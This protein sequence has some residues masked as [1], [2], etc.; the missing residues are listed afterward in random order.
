MSSKFRFFEDILSQQTP[1]IDDTLTLKDQS[2]VEKAVLQ[3]FEIFEECA[4]LDPEL[5][6]IKRKVHVGYLK[7]SLCHIPRAYECLDASRPW[8]CYWILNALW[9]LNEMPDSNTLSHVVTFLSKCQHE[10]G[11]YGGGPGQD[12]HLAPTY[13]AINALTIIGTQEAYDSINRNTLQQFLWGVRSVDGA[14]AMHRGG[15]V[16]VRGTYCALNVAKLTN[17]FTDALFDKTAEWI[18]SCQTYEGGFGGSQGME[19]HGG[20][21]F[22][23]IAGLTILG[24]PHLCD[25]DALLR[26][27]V[28][29]QMKLEG[30]FQGRTNKLVD[31]CYSFWQGGIFPIIH[32]I[33]FQ[34]D[35]ISLDGLLFNQGALQEYILVCCENP[36]GGFIDKPGK[37]RD[38]Y[39]TNYVLSGL[40]IAQHGLGS[41]SD[42]VGNP[43]NKLNRVH[44]VHCI[45]PHLAYNGSQ[46]FTKY[47][48]SPNDKN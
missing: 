32:T 9:L 35:G 26:W 40:S 21:A 8:M 48:A 14:F 7:S 45:A 1:D 23:A 42:V 17:L 44:P 4:S 19:A 12:S 10:E 25:I 46:Y 20:Y 38:L 36:S 47:P 18:V 37:R 30:G 11:G 34:R 31:G 13:A 27:C 16:D 15:E 22:C 2:A 6:K 33:L 41:E 5:P 29:R 3:A 28:N 43:E 39:H 24:R